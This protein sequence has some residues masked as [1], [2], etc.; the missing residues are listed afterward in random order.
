MVGQPLGHL[1]D[2]AT[3]QA[4]Q[5]PV[6]GPTGPSRQPGDVPPPTT[7]YRCPEL[8][9]DAWTPAVSQ[10]AQPAQVPG[11]ERVEQVAKTN[12]GRPVECW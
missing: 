3:D 4:I 1:S 10:L 11:V 9:E 12:V 2:Q 8:S 7:T 6:D 5:R